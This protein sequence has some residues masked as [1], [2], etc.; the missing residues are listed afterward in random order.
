MHDTPLIPVSALPDDALV[1]DVRED[2]EWHAGHAPNAIHIPMGSLPGRLDALPETDETVPVICR[3]GGRSDRAVRWL[4]QQGFDVV[5]VD[6]GMRA[7]AAA[8][9]AMTSE[10]GSEPAVL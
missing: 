7:W 4:V 2:D 8:G 1:V 10:D 5:N 9:K 3:S 6:G